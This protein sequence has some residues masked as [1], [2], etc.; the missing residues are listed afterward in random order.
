MKSIAL[1]DDYYEERSDI[2]A[3]DY[4]RI[5]EKLQERFSIL[6]AWDISLDWESEYC[7]ASRINLQE[8]TQHIA[9]LSSRTLDSGVS[10]EGYLLHEILH[11][12]FAEVTQ[13]EHR[14]NIE[15]EQEMEAFCSRYDR[16]DSAI[17]SLR[18][19]VEDVRKQPTL[20]F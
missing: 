16:E 8:H 19:L 17:E 14:A 3:E 18:K 4:T 11:A 10:L 2:P 5:I 15:N 7:D 9:P 12:V 6:N 13:Y 1:G 20:F